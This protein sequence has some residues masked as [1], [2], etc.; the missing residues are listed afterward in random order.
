MK[1]LLQLLFG[2][3]LFVITSCKTDVPAPYP[4]PQAHADK[5]LFVYMPWS[6]ARNSNFGS[7][8]QAFQRNISDM[9]TAIEADGGLHRNRLIIFI[10]TSSSSA[11][12]MEITYKNG[13][14]HE[15]TL[16][17]YAA[18]NLP[19]LTTAGGIANVLGTMKSKAP[20]NQYAMIIGCHGTG[21]LFSN[22]GRRVS[23]R[24]FGGSEP[25]TQT[26]IPTLAEAISRTGMH[27]Q[28]IMFDDC[29]MSNIEVAYELRNVTSH[30]IGCAS[31]VMAYGM[32]YHKMWR[33]LVQ[34]SPDYQRIVNEFHNFYS[35]Y[36]TP[37]GNIGI[38]DCAVAEEMAGVM[39][40]INAAYT[41][42][43]ADTLQVQKL[44]G[45]RNTIFYDMGDY[46]DKLCGGTAL[47]T[48]FQSTLS[49]LVPYKSTTPS[50]YTNLGET[51]SRYISVTRFSGITISDPTVS[52]YESAFLNKTRTQWWQVTH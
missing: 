35:T 34:L 12:M 51:P 1:K 14:C 39:K 36:S 52:S 45:Y 50:I 22:G 31:E 33:Y 21:W 5:T 28:F 7:L 15:D 47:Y 41:F 49:R 46:V 9:K 23:T 44:D 13:V 40:Q 6:A 17:R 20:A 2:T 18:A 10:S 19:E 37:C 38:T 3:L 24:Y 25:Y 27:M 29:Y 43:L 11:V 16:E 8:Y 30:L 42:N 4:L 48:A 26:N 32:P